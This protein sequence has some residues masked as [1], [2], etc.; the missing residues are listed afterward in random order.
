MLLSSTPNLCEDFGLFSEQSGEKSAD[1]VSEKASS[2]CAGRCLHKP[3]GAP[4]D[5]N[6]KS[7]K[8]FN[9]TKF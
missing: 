5:Q 1:G 2:G 9:F 4:I 6:L 8:I 3:C 7:A